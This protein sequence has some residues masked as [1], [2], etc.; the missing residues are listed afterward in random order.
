MAAAG[1]AL[2]MASMTVSRLVN[3]FSAPKDALPT[4]TWMMFCLSRR[5]S[6]LPAL[7]SLTALPRSGVTV[8]ALGL[9]IRPR[10]PSSL[11]RRPTLP[12]MSGVVT[13]TSK[14]MKPPWILAIRSSSPTISAP[15]ASA[16]EAA[17]PLAMA[18]TRTVLPVPLGSTTAPRTC[19]SA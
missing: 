18:Q 1:F 16:A 5:Y 8:P 3:S 19:W 4:G 15:A 12:I 13:T 9:G 11:P 2:A 6:I 7:A 14:S 10:G 17:G